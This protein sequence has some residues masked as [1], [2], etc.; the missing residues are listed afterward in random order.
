LNALNHLEKVVFKEDAWPVFDLF[1]NLLMPGTIRLKA[2]VG[3]SIVGFICVEQNWFEKNASI[4]TVGV[5]PGYR[6][7]GVARAMMNSVEEQ[8]TRKI[9]RLSVRVSN[10]GAIHLYE[11][12]GYFKR[13]TRQRYYADG[14]DAFE[15]EKLI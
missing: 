5:D 14:E 10:L 4:T 15:M 7:Q 8:I 13:K 12:L 11:E 3:D 2:Q 9:I 6:R 1:A